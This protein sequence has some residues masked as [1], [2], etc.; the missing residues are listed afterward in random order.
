MKKFRKLIPA[1]CMLLVSALFVGT[2]TYAWFS[3]NDTVT[4]TEMKV[5]AV[6]NAKYL[7]IGDNEENA[8]TAK[9]D[10]ENAALNNTHKA[11]APSNTAL[12]PAFYGDGVEKLGQ[13]TA[14]TVGHWYTANSNSADSATEDTINVKDI[15]ETD[16]A[17]LGKYVAEYKVWLTLSNDSEDYTGNIK[18]TMNTRNAGTHDS[19]KALVKVN[20]TMLTEG[21][22][23]KAKVFAATN[24]SADANAVSLSKTTAVPVSILV[25]VDGTDDE[26]KTNYTIDNLK[27]DLS[28]SFKLV[29][30]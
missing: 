19:V 21:T 11:L 23:S 29:N 9:T 24:D 10:S 15:T 8:K 17:N 20:N 6:T 22:E 18:V 25:F 5:T 1:L 3:M 30:P 13:S 12:Y 28:F 2:S 7:L 26:V 27:G 16:S 4:A 14:T